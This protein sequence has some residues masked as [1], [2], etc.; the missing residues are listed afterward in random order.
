[1]KKI[2]VL[3]F[4]AVASASFF[5]S[6]KGEDKNPLKGTWEVV[7]AVVESEYF[8]REDVLG[9]TYRFTDTDVIYKSS[10]SSPDS[11][12]SQFKYIDKTHYET[13][14][15]AFDIRLT[16]TFEFKGSGKNKQLMVK[17]DNGFSYTMVRVRK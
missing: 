4:V 17:S 8:T 13:Y 6:C 5:T 12:T 7:D 3:L 16:Y 10:A 9:G 1:M 2:Y 11:S 14:N 15:P